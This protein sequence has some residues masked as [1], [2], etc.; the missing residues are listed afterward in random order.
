MIRK[1]H[2]SELRMDLVSN[3]W[4]VI[5]TKRKAKPSSFV[6]RKRFKPSTPLKAC[7]FCK[8]KILKKAVSMHKNPDNNWFVLSMPNDFPAFSK[9]RNL[10]ERKEGP[11]KIMN[12]L[13]Y[14]EVIVTADHCRQMAQFSQEELKMVREQ[15]K[16]NEFVFRSDISGK[17]LKF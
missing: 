4:V 6:K 1:K 13:G 15:A 11:N 10:N 14:Q 3:D 2:S 8:S 12:G 7:P 16:L 17:I 9:S 5:A